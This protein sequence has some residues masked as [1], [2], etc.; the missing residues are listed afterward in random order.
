[1]SSETPTTTGTDASSPTDPDDSIDNRSELVFLY[2]AVDTNPNGDPLTEENRPRV[3]DYT[4]EGIVSDVRL[5]RVVRDALDRRGETILIK[6]SGETGRDDK[7]DR[8]AA[9]KEEMRPL[10][11]EDG[12][13]MTE[14]EAFLATATDVRL[15]GESMT[16]DSPISG[17]YTGPVQFNFGRTMHAVN[18]TSHGKTSVVAADSEEGDRTEGGNM[19]TEYRL[20]YALVRFHGVINEHNAAETGLSEEDVELLEDGL[21]HG[22]R[23][24]TNTA[25]KQ[26]HEPRLLVR[27]EYAEDDWH[28]GDLH[29]SFAA[30]PDEMA[31][32]AMRD[33]TDAIVDANEFVSLL[34]AHGE[35]IEAVHVRASRR[36][37]VR[38][39]D[40]DGGAF[41]LEQ[42]MHD[43]LGSERLSFTVE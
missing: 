7:D 19:F 34:D 35:K 10:M 4:G 27:V 39:G 22:T 25:S 31:E 38:V 32:R 12:P 9:I 24:E 5:K 18:E 13:N 40:V 42:A 37:R 26:G 36:L 6:A 23:N 43:A 20:D 16:F 29:R 2:D 11:E 30:E 28:I 14:E 41:D 3:D 17:S 8:Y 21:W 1:M 15:F 33:V